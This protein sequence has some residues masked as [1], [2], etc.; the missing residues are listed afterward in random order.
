MDQGRDSVG[1]GTITLREADARVDVAPAIG[2]SLAS[3]YWLRR[4]QRF[5]WLRPAA[6]AALAQTDAGELGCFPLVPYSNRVRQGR[7]RFAGRQIQLA[8]D[9]ATD[10][11]FQHGHGC[12]NPWSM[13]DQ[14]EAGIVLSYT[15]AADDWPWRYTARQSIRLAGGALHLGLDLTNQADAVMPLGLGFHPY[16]PRAPGTRL[17]AAVN[18]M[19]AIDQEVL[20][21]TL[22]PPPAQAD[23]N[24][25]L[26]LDRVE[27]DNVFTGWRRRAEI[28]WP[29]A[30]LS[31]EA[32]AP[33]DFLVVYVPAG[34]TYFCAEPVSNATDAFN[35]AAAG[36]TDTGMLALAPGE[37]AR[38]AMRIV[39]RLN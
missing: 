5:D 29:S 15:H 31:I 32:E 9:P 13:V 36:R 35:L 14:S 1:F 21:T 30:S 23:P 8:V 39:P 25:G 17:N 33:L 4:G 12:R 10:P 38:A 28:V 24:T 27:L 2:G 18:G 26:D 3:Y 19:W 34:E 7:F 16:F 22:G 11:H 6:P 37:T 20:P